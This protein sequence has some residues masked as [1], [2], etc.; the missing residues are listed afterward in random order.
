M[1]VCLR[2]QLR[3]LGVVFRLLL[4]NVCMS[5]LNSERGAETRTVTG[6]RSGRTWRLR[7]SLHL[8]EPFWWRFLGNGRFACTGRISRRPYGPGCVDGRLGI[9]RAA[10]VSYQ[11]VQAQE[12]CGSPSLQS[13][14]PGMRLLLCL[15]GRFLRHGAMDLLFLRHCRCYCV[16]GHSGHHQFHRSN[17]RGSTK[18]GRVGS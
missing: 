15:E 10:L 4:N 12:G 7:R 13:P 2:Q 17:T 5:L 3:L 14:C 6:N 18:P 8:L 11:I 16:C 1:V 9:E